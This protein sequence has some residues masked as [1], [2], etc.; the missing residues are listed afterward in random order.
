MCR[1]RSESG[2]TET[3]AVSGVGHKK[4]FSR[5]HNSWKEEKRIELAA[6]TLILG[7]IVE[8]LAKEGTSQIRTPTLHIVD[9]VRLGGV[10]VRN[11][12]I[13][14]RYGTIVAPPRLA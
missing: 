11:Y 10:D 9:A 5:R 8:E 12:V 1:E 3:P 4:V 2:F 7:E 6:D 14:E 13:S